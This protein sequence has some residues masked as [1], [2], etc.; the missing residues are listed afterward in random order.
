MIPYECGNTYTLKGEG[1]IATKTV[2][3]TEDNCILYF[4][5]NSIHSLKPKSTSKYAVRLTLLN[6][7]THKVLLVSKCPKETILHDEM[8][9]RPN[10]VT[11]H[12][13]DMDFMVISTDD[14]TIKMQHQVHRTLVFHYTGILYFI[15]FEVLFA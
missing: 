11:T 7:D 2:S 4:I 1:T 8:I 5:Y 10:C 9:D 13:S 14:I 15:V 12:L 6:L 3:N